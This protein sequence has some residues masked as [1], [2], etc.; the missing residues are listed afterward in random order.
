MDTEHLQIFKFVDNDEAI[1]VF[2][3][4]HSDNHIY[5]LSN[6]LILDAVFDTSDDDVTKDED[7][8][9]LNIRKRVCQIAKIK[10]ADDSDMVIFM[11]LSKI[12][13]YAGMQLHYVLSRHYIEYADGHC[14][15]IDNRV[16]LY[17][18][19]QA[20]AKSRFMYNLKKFYYSG[21]TIHPGFSCDD[22]VCFMDNI[23]RNKFALV[24]AD[25][26]MDYTDIDKGYTY[27]APVFDKDS[28]YNLESGIQHTDD[29]TAYGEIKQQDPDVAFEES[30]DPRTIESFMKMYGGK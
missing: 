28:T 7:W 11:P 10:N 29:D 8:F 27:E 2:Y 17:A 18:K 13:E 21:K 26:K 20:Q 16:Y 6:A 19:S 3:K 1:P 30:D 5:R 15:Y 4:H 23:S 12:F 14:E 24:L 9:Y 25:F 22:M